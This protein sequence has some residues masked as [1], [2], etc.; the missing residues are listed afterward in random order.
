MPEYRYTGQDER[1]Y[2]DRG[3]LAAPG[4]TVVLDGE[5]DDNWSLGDRPPGASEQEGPAHDTA[6]PE[7][8]TDTHDTEH[9]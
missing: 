3:L 1:Y 9:V 6:A 5:L 2:P 4:D 8:P 7:Q